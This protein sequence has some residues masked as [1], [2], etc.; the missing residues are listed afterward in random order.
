M[1]LRVYM[2]WDRRELLASQVC[3]RS[4]LN[5]ASHPV[6]ISPLIL[7]HLQA[8]G[9]YTRPTEIRATRL[10]DV[11]SQHAMAT[12]HAL[13]RFLVPALNDYR[14]WALFCDG[15]ILWRADVAE[16]FALA[17]PAYAVMVV[18]HDHKPREVAKMDGQVQAQYEC[19]NWS[20]VILWNCAHPANA[21]VR[22]GAVNTKPGLWLHQFRWLAPELIGGLP[23][24]WNWLEG[25][26][27]PA[28][29]P[30]AVHHTRGT[31]DMVGYRDVAYA[32]EWRAVAKTIPA[33]G[34]RKAAA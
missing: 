12:D 28:L 19:K 17:D 14:G 4:M 15:D 2:G 29:T 21:A 7:P 1:S 27:D 22:V 31:P 32:D 23:A 25:H 9:L 8:T 20:S 33:F 24:E 5:H 18:K 26:S 3:A 34:T 10:F 6:D 13:A 30:K 11:I 16:L